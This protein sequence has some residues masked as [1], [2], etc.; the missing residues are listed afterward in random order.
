MQGVTAITH[1][2]DPAHD[3]YLPD[4]LRVSAVSAYPAAKPKYLVYLLI[5]RPQPTNP[6]AVRSIALQAEGKIGQS[7]THLSAE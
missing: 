1:H 6:D 3:G 5:D 7:L 2:V 4:A